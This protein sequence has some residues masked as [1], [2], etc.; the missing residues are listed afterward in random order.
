M[1]PPR[2]PLR[3]ALI[4]V[5]VLGAREAEAL[6][7]LLGQIQGTLWDAYGDA[8]LDHAADDEPSP[9][10]YPGPPTDRND[11]PPSF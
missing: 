6:I 1:K 8:I 3:V 7:D 4:E 9:E 11:D 2:P 5:P 10:D